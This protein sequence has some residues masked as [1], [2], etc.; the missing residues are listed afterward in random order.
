MKRKSGVLLPISSLPGN[1]GIGDLGEEAYRFVDQLNKAGFTTWQLLPLNPVGPGNSPY[2]AYSAYAGEPM[3]VSVEMLN[4]WNLLQ[5]NDL[6]EI[7]RFSDT[8]VDYP[9]VKAYK[10]GLLSKAWNHFKQRADEAFQNEFNH[11]KEEHDWWLTDYALYA[12]CKEKFQ[13]KAWNEWPDE[14][15]TRNKKAL[16]DLIVENFDEVEQQ[17]FIQFMFFRQWF[18]L[19]Q[20]SNQNNVE[21]FGDLPLYVSLDSSDVWGNQ[22]LFLLDEDGFPE[23]IGG[24]PPDYFSEDGQLWGNPVFDWEALKATEYQWWI[25]RLYFNF[26]LYNLVRIDHFRGLESFWAVPSESETAKNGYWMPAYGFDLL[27]KLRNQLGELPVVAEDLGIIT[28]EVEK[29]RDAFHLPGMKVLQFA[30][31][32]DCTNVHLPHN[33][34]GR[35]IA[36]TGTHDNNTLIGWLDEAD[37]NEREL[38]NSY[39]IDADNPTNEIIRMAWSSSAEM[40]IVPM[41]D[42]LHLGGKFRMNTPGVATG[43]WQ[44]RYNSRQMDENTW[45]TYKTLNKLYNRNNE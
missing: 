14:L 8:N 13:G 20:Y 26:H 18:Q 23:L 11:F 17:K 16:D 27:E 9:K 37:K 38:V 44:W 41:Q 3:Y 45:E 36:Y 6:K 10:Y 25:S 12:V 19:K 40:A 1:G 42:V 4:K 15:K 35:T 33:Y 24:V 2:Q 28:P 39:L 21:L 30:F 22:H 7:P 31:S 43:N 34:T 5:E 32:T 29:L